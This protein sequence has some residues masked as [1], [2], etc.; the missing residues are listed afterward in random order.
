MRNFSR[1][2]W[3]CAFFSVLLIL[4]LANSASAQF[5]VTISVD[6]N[7]NGTL[8][9]TTGFHS[10][11]TGAMLPDP[12]PGDLP[13]AL[14]YG[15]LNPPGLTA[16]DLIILEPGNALIS[17][18]VRFNPSQNG[19]SLSSPINTTHDSRCSH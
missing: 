10:V 2:Q 5:T 15:L 8:D 16:G 18:I 19:G 9:N 1:F 17:D 11:L 4:V 7:G 14:T 12:G 3:L 6:E 13:S